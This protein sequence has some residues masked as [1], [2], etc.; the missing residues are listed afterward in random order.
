MSKRILSLLSL[1]NTLNIL[2]PLKLQKLKDLKVRDERLGKALWLISIGRNAL[3]VLGASVF[4][5]CTYDPNHLIVKL[6][7]MCHICM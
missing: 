2:C 7:G 1:F 6:S 5:Y 4:A 3:V